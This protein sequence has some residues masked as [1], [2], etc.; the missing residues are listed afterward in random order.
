M[1]ELKKIVFDNEGYNI[2]NYTS[3]KYDDLFKSSIKYRGLNY[4]FNNRVTS[5]NNKNNNITAVVKG[6]DNYNVSINNYGSD[7]IEVKCECPYHNET[8][9]YCKHVYA[10]IISLEFPSKKEELENIFKN[11]IIKM[12]DIKDKLYSIVTSNKEYLDQSTY[13]W[14]N[15]MFDQ[16]KIILN[17]MNSLFSSSDSRELLYAIP[18]AYFNL[19]S[20]IDNYNFIVDRVI[21]GKQEAEIR[22]KLEQEEIERQKILE[23]E[24]ELER[25]RR[26]ELIRRKYELEAKRQ[27]KELKRLKKIQRKKLRKLLWIG[28]A[29]FIKGAADGLSEMDHYYPKK[30]SKK[31]NFDFLMDWEEDLVNKGEYEPYNFEEE[32]MDEEDYYYEDD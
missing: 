24:K 1:D 27:K 11:N 13:L 32:E 18:K 6:N 30:R 25:K 10:L 5:V 17:D 14:I 31:S 4:Y 29:A 7:N 15:E 9:I 26:E 16:Y 2:L 19:H 8:D 22:K 23:E 21:I 12:K 20:I 3:T 28:V